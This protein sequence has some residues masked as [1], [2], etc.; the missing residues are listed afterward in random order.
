[1]K[2]FN[3]NR[4]QSLPLGWVRR[5][6]DFQHNVKDIQC[7]ASGGSG[8]EAAA[9]ECVGVRAIKLRLVIFSLL[10]CLTASVHGQSGSLGFF[11][12][13]VTDSVG[14]YLSSNG[15][16]AG[17]F[18]VAGQPVLTLWESAG[19]I[20]PG[21]SFNNIKIVSSNTLAAGQWPWPAMTIG[22]ANVSAMLTGSKCAEWQSGANMVGFLQ[23]RGLNAA[24]VTVYQVITFTTVVPQFNNF[25]W[26]N[27]NTAPNNHNMYDNFND[28]PDPGSYVTIENEISTQATPLL[29]MT[30]NHTLAVITDAPSGGVMTM[31]VWDCASQTYLGSATVTDNVGSGATGPANWTTIQGI[32]GCEN[33][34][35]NTATGENFDTYGTVYVLNGGTPVPAYSAPPTNSALPLMPVGWY[36]NWTRSGVGVQGGIPTVTNVFCNCATGVCSNGT[37]TNLAY[38]FHGDNVNDDSGILASVLAHCPS[39]WVIYIPTGT[40]LMTNLVANY[41]RNGVVIR[42]DGA[43]KTIWHEKNPVGSSDALLVGDTYWI[44]TNAA[45][46]CPVHS[47]LT[48]GSSNISVVSV[49]GNAASITVGMMLQID[50]LNTN[51]ATGDMEN[52]FVTPFGSDALG[53]YDRPHNGSRC[54]SQLTQVKAISQVTNLT[55][56]PPIQWNFDM[57]E[58]PQVAMMEA[59]VQRFGLENL[60]I[61]NDVANNTGQNLVDFEGCLNCWEKGVETAYAKR[62][63]QWWNQCLFCEMRE[64]TIHDATTY[65][66]DYGYGL[67]VPGCTDCLWEDNIEYNL[68][69]FVFIEGG[70][71]GNVYG[72]NYL[73]NLMGSSGF[74]DPYI[75]IHVPNPVMNLVEGN[76]CPNVTFDHTHGSGG[77]CQTVFRNALQ[78][79]SPTNYFYQNIIAV[80]LDAWTLSNNIVGNVLGEPSRLYTFDLGDTNNY[81]DYYTSY[82]IRK[83]GYPASAKTTYTGSPTAVPFYPLTNAYDLRVETNTFWHENYDYAHMSTVISNG[84]A[85][86][87]PAS[88][89]YSSQPS[90]WPVGF[91]W[92]PIGP[93]RTP[94]VSMIPA[95]ARFNALMNPGPPT[96]GQPLPAPTGLHVVP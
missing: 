95:Q 23:G 9:P 60:T 70:C 21:G 76:V 13:L 79:L 14:S 27:L 2:I 7:D 58:S 5:G 85:T 4:S 18:K 37:I 74:Q 91:A 49:A 30:F 51:M 66:I 56:W 62:W 48:I 45:R 38:R 68:L 20:S 57:A 84:Y 34:E 71:T 80:D 47:G 61:S 77:T 64:C 50:Q 15:V 29:H 46:V 44:N 16:Y 82:A 22:G 26:L 72:Y 87:L 92:P 25:D 86:T 83:F 36:I 93:D 54:L 55:V 6:P 12:D 24:Q 11:P 10:L 59:P 42:G 17:T 73:T 53:N 43:G 32:V 3:R 40:Y 89:Y 88:L 90:W 69:M 81:D 96:G 31:Y 75:G 35:E 28:H 1:M 19:E 52:S 65:S 33:T 94:M 39:N 63:H 67:E 41:N 8:E 78:E